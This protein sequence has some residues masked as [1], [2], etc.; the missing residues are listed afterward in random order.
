M[1]LALR[2]VSADDARLLW[3]WRN[4]PLVRANSFTQDFISWESHCAWF[5]AKLAQADCRIWILESD[6]HPAGQARYDRSGAIAEIGYSIAEPF[7][8]AG[9][10]AHLLRMSGPLGCRALGVSKLIG[11]VKAGNVASIRSFERSGFRCVETVMRHDHLCVQCE[12]TCT[13]DQDGASEEP[14]EEQ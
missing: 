11:V 13:Q 10:G 7:R 5:A 3:E 8:G 9:L 2:G 12:K 14:S 4:D 1:P 6:G